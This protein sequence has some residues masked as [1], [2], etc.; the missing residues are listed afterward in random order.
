MSINI[1][2][3]FE[4]AYIH[5]SKSSARQNMKLKFQAIRHNPKMD[6]RP[7]ESAALG[8]LKISP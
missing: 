2:E 6:P 8:V 1:T 3:N 4:R 5:L 7:L